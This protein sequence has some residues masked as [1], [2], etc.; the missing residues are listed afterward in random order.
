MNQ[1]RGFY[2]SWFKRLSLYLVISCKS[3][4]G[5][6]SP[7]PVLPSSAPFKPKMLSLYPQIPG[8][9][10]VPSHLHGTTVNWLHQ[11]NWPKNIHFFLIDQ[12]GKSDEWE[13]KAMFSHKWS[14][15][16]CRNADVPN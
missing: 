1:K 14:M 7:F 10:S 12:K 13:S 15:R 16:I 2:F 5:F 9:S 3:K 6:S 8:S 4:G 11:L